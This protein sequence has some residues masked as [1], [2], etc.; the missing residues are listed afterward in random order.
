MEHLKAIILKFVMCTGILWIVLGLF[1]GV[2]FGEIVTISV[3]LTVAAYAIGDL[4]LLRYFNNPIA[5][6][7]DFGLSFLVIWFL[8]SIIID[9]PIPIVTAS[10]ISAFLLAVGEWFYHNYLENHIFQYNTGDERTGLA[11]EFA[12]EHDVHNLNNRSERDDNE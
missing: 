9:V 11:T 12:E 10:L 5:T 2:G 3:I 8:G 6:A 1:Y 4:L 7:A